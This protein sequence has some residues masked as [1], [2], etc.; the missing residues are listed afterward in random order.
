MMSILEVLPR[1]RCQECLLDREWRLA[2]RKPGAIGNPENVRVD[3]NRC[4]AEHHVENDVRR[5]ASDPRKRFERGAIPGNL[6]R[7]LRDELT[8]KANEILGLRVVKADAFQ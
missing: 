1:S 7:V 3:G 6:T 2:R 8:R 4:L 5:L